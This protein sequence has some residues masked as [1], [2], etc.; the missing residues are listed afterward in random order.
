MKLLSCLFA[1][2]AGI[3]RHR[4]RVAVPMHWLKGER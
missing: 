3:T 2:P 4:R 1:E